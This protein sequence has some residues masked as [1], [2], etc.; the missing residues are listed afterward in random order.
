MINLSLSD[1]IIYEKLN[2]FLIEKFRKNKFID[3]RDY[4]LIKYNEINF[5]N[6]HYILGDFIRV[7][8]IDNNKVVIFQ[9]LLGNK[10]FAYHLCEN[11]LSFGF[12]F[13]LYET[14]LNEKKNITFKHIKENTYIKGEETVFKNIK[15]FLGLSE[16]VISKGKLKTLPMS[17]YRLLELFRTK[18][19][20]KKL[21]S[22]YINF[23]GKQNILFS[24]GDDSTLISDLIKN[25]N[26]I[27]R[28]FGF[29]DSEYESNYIDYKSVRNYPR[30]TKIINIRENI[31]KEF[32]SSK[33]YR[34]LIWDFKGYS[35]S[36]YNFYLIFKN[37]Q[38]KKNSSILTGQGADS[39]GYFGPSERFYFNGFFPRNIKCL[40]NRLRL[41]Y[42]LL[43]KRN[44]KELYWLIFNDYDYSFSN[45][46][47]YFVENKFI[48]ELISSLE[49]LNL[50]KFELNLI[51]MIFAKTR[52]FGSGN[53][54]KALHYIG[55]K[56][57]H[58]FKFP[59]NNIFFA[60]KCYRMAIK[61]PILH[62]IFPK[63]WYSK[64]KERFFRKRVKLT[65][66][67][68]KNTTIFKHYIETISKIKLKSFLK[69]D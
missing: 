27:Q 61:N 23:L 18:Y 59:L 52:S 43:F 50:R 67:H 33:E 24:G 35:H 46:N 37:L 30:K 44:I 45:S 42:L 9:D 36:L 69:L 34:N 2:D 31:C 53:D 26:T 56:L 47:L 55:Y 48:N 1:E 12:E 8:K 19:K 5:K 7:E 25:E 17:P 16:L 54:I 14:A 15:R 60:I 21:F 68:H 38:L 13:T 41:I 64:A 51:I 39:I 40:L 62:I 3:I 4:S 10:S 49:K 65:K 29:I 63:Y 6:Y 11:K 22:L 58:E 66:K 57:G 32:I 20:F 28:F